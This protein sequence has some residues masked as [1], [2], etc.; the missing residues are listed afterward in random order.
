[1]VRRKVWAESAAKGLARSVPMNYADA[2]RKVRVVGPDS[3]N[4]RQ[5]AVLE[6]A[7][8]KLVLMGESSGVTAD[9][10]ILL[11]QAGLTVP[12]LLQYVVATEGPVV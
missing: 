7:V 4:F 8:G 5:R 6:S 12:E 9:D 1:M 10:M 11:L 2:V 3:L